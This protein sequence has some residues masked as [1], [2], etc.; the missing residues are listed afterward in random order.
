MFGLYSLYVD[1][2][3]C[4]PM[5]FLTKRSGYCKRNCADILTGHSHLV[6]TLCVVRGDLKNISYTE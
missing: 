2:V 4:L 1:R 6:S 3:R 5:Y